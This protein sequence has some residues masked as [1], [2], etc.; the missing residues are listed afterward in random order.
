MKENDP[1]ERWY[2]EFSDA[3]EPMVM[4]FEFPEWLSC[5]MQRL[6]SRVTAVVLALPRERAKRAKELVSNFLLAPVQK[7]FGRDPPTCPLENENLPPPGFRNGEQV[8]K[9]LNWQGASRKVTK[10]P[11]TGTMLPFKITPSTRICQG[12]KSL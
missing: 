8:C 9:P 7:L 4:F 11:S 3:V 1:D 6:E 2:R 12:T 5:P 10:V